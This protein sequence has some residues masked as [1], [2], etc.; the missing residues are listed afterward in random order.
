VAG[1]QG[2]QGPAGV[3]GATGPQ[4]PQA[5]LVYASIN[6][7]PA[8]GSDSA[9]F[10]DESTSRLYQWESPFYV[11]VG[12]SGGG[13]GGAATTSASDLTSGTL[14]DARLSANIATHARRLTPVSLQHF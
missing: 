12:T 5:S 14:P 2:I 9:L 7:F 8:T 6:D 3:A 1:Q 10:L 11:E 4:G 13:G